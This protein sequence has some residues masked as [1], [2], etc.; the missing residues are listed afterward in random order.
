MRRHMLRHASW[1]RDLESSAFQN[2][3]AECTLATWLHHLIAL[4]MISQLW[5]RKPLELLFQPLLRR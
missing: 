2:G 1:R 3:I 5:D 4:S